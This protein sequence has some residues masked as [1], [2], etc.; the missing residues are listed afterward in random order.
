MGSAKMDHIRV[1]ITGVGDAPYRARAVEQALEGT[2]CSAADL[3]D[4]AGHATDG[5]TVNSDIHADAE[6]RTELTK[7]LV[8]RALE[9]ARART[10]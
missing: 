7:T 10:G 9:Q 2:D 5:Q 3:A 4:A 6:Y 1:G 8:R